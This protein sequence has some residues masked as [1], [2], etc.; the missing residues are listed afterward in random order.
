[1]LAS[2]CRGPCRG[3]IWGAAWQSGTCKRGL[4]GASHDWFS[5]LRGAGRLLFANSTATTVVLSG[6]DAV[7][8][9]YQNT[10]GTTYR[11][12]T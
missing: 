3:L 1:M 4:C 6:Q 11:G 9:K 10:R 7:V 8:R 2:R 5:V 12:T